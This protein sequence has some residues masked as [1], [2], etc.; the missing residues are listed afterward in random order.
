MVSGK[1]NFFGEVRERAGGGDF[2]MRSGNVRCDGC[3]V[4]VHANAVSYT[5][6][7]VFSPFAK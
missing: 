1:G 3:A 4:C 7:Y 2:A 6:P 5:I